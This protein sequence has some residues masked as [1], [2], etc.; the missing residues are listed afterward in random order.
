VTLAQRLLVAIGILTIA[1][2]ATLG[3]GVR[4]AWRRTEEARFRE[5]FL[6][7]FDRLQ[8]RAR[9]EIRDLP[10]L[11]APRCSH[12]TV[13]DSALVDLSAHRLDPG[14]RLSLSLRVP[15]MME[16]MRLDE[17][18]L[19]TGQGEVLGAGHADGLVGKRDPALAAILAQPAESARV[20][21]RGNALSIQAHCVRSRR[22]R[23]VG[24][25]AARHLDHLLQDVASGRGVKLSLDAGAVSEDEM[26][27]TMKLP[28]LGGIPVVATASRTPLY[29]ALRS[30]DATILA[31]GAGTFGVALVLAMLL[32]RGLARPIV[33]LSRQARRVV[34]GT[35]E[36]VKG[37]G[38]RE[39]EELAEAFNRAIRDLTAM[40]RRLAATE[41]IAARR[42]I[43]RRVAHEIKNPLAP[44]RA[45]VET[46]RRL[47]ARGDPAFDDYFD[48]A[49]RTVLDEVARISNIVAEFTRFARLPPPNP[50]P[51]DLVDAVRK[52][53]SLHGSAEAGIELSTQAC[54]E[55]VADKDQIVQVMTNLLQNALEA[56]Q[57]LDG[58]HVL[59]EVRPSGPE[60]VAI[61]VAD[62]GPG[63]APEMRDRLFEP[64]ATTKAE[65]TGLGLAIV[66][67]IVVEH[68]GE[69]S[70]QDGS[71]GGAE[72]RITLPVAGPT[73]LP[74][75]PT[76]TPL[77]TG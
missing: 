13:V 52:V 45:A 57:T 37:R 14:R 44:I 21:R 23:A 22:G 25:I 31:L 61:R 17:L 60:A 18:T 26:A 4:E 76:S 33:S 46:L 68:D 2:T 47:Q 16:A 20:H 75:A 66:H 71:D 73:L 56:C 43:A 41:R 6:A 32:S 62:N 77:G 42:E 30:L 48:E 49:T 63:L 51:M 54:P 15:Q 65:G 38:G 67:R 3:F 8:H 27:L 9:E 5:Q 70:Y 24:L 28:E 53:V 59:V 35:P 50:A 40:R 34:H 39:L 7:A 72:F 11:I 19:V 36:P 69:I 74:E 29:A 64:Y 1:T 12:D 10:A 55:V 58:A